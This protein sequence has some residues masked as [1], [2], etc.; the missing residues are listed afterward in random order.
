MIKYYLLNNSILYKIDTEIDNLTEFQLL[1]PNAEELTQE[2]YDN[3]IEHNLSNRDLIINMWKPTE[4]PP[5]TIE[6]IKTSMINQYSNLSFIKRQELLPDYK[7]I[8]GAL[9]VY[10]EEKKQLYIEIVN[11]FRNE[12][13][14][15]KNL[16]DQSETKEE[17]DGITTNFESIINQ[18][19][20]QV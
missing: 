16:V 17:L 7:L 3:A 10:G 13:Y 2:Q 14:R 19:K 12:Y 5:P 6:E 8:N 18:Y 4:P 9:G 20:N 11:A 15:L 1:Y